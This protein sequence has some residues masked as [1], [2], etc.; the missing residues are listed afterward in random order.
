MA[1]KEGKPKEL[2]VLIG[3]ETGFET[4]IREARAMG[5]MPE[6]DYK[7]SHLPTE[8]RTLA[9]T[10][11][12]MG[13]LLKPVD[14]EN[15]K[16]GEEMAAIKRGDR[17][18]DGWLPD[19]I[20]MRPPETFANPTARDMDFHESFRLDEAGAAGVDK[21]VQN[22]VLGA[23]NN[24]ADIQQVRSDML[25]FDFMMKHGVTEKNADAYYRAVDELLPEVIPGNLAMK[26]TAHFVG[27]DG[28]V[29]EG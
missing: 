28:E 7:V 8:D 23:F 16:I 1:L 25:S 10:E 15:V 22:Y 5:L 24:G 21:M 6:E 27:P 17:D 3:N 13:K 14:M 4:A 2:E 12:G 18:E 9:I 11:S 20:T 26:R 29:L 19:G